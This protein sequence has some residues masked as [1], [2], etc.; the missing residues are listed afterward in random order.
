MA[1]T[2][3]KNALSVP[4]NL[5]ES[6]WINTPFAYTE[7]FGGLSLLQQDIM[8]K[9]SDNIQEFLKNYFEEGRDKSHAKPRPLFTEYE[10]RHSLKPIRV[11]FAD[12]GV[13]ANHY[14]QIEKAVKEIL[15]IN[16]RVPVNKNNGER[17]L[18][19]I[20]IFSKGEAPITEGGY[21]YLQKVNDV[22]V[23][24]KNVSRSKG[25]IDFHI[26]P[27]V[28]DYVFDMSKGYINHPNTIA[29]ISTMMHTP[30]LYGL[31]KSKC[32]G[33]CSC[34][35]TVN[36]IKEHLGLVER[37]KDNEVESY[38]FPKYAHFKKYVLLKVQDDLQ[39]LAA[40][41]Q[42]DY[43][44]NFREVRREGRSTGD[45]VY[46][47]FEL[48]RTHLGDVRDL[49]RHRRSAN[50]KLIKTLLERCGDLRRDVIE[51]IINSVA[52]E[53]FADFS[54]YVY[55]DVKAIIEHQYPD[56]VA[57]YTV[58]LMRKWIEACQKRKAE[59]KAQAQ[60][61][62]DLFS[63]QNVPVETRSFGEV[64][65]EFAKEWQIILSKYDGVLKPHLL[66]AKHQG[67]SRGFVWIDFPDKASADAFEKAE[68]DNPKEAQ[69]FT[70]IMMSVLGSNGRIL[71]RGYK[72]DKGI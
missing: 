35:L 44:F 50:Q 1:R 40:A 53:D 11:V 42:I 31:L 57:T 22:E 21:T 17:V 32:A 59:A 33:T 2:S 27:A 12:Y 61:E 3:K 54:T 25:W 68:H 34:K 7:F 29:R 41:D 55:R 48:V 36:E 16:I 28:A 24:I 71:V 4:A 62:L 6:R 51:P 43:T 10:K 63:S 37:N 69:R 20:N 66:R 13:S 47:E 60:G 64:P 70:A 65:G 26:N 19:W 67:S 30:S 9:V 39:R 52:D 56:D 49:A 14:D 18:T 5:T 38:S 23:Q 15:Q 8:Y 58:A 72:K 46:I 45:P